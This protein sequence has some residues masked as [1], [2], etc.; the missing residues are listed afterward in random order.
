MKPLDPNDHEVRH[1]IVA[2]Q[3]LAT[4][5]KAMAAATETEDE[6]VFAIMALAI[7]YSILVAEGVQGG[8]FTLDEAVGMAT[9]HLATMIR[10]LASGQ[11]PREA[12]DA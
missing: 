5:A 4:G 3:G 7:G 2:G 9:R 8:E 6:A 11:V 10:F 12:L 1:A